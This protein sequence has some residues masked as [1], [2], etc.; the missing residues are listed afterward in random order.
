MSK[1]FKRNFN[2][3]LLRVILIFMIIVHHILLRGCG[4]RELYKNSF[5]NSNLIFSFINAFL[6]VAVNCFFLISGYYGIKKNYEKIVKLV[7]A[8]YS[9]YWAIN[10]VGLIA[11]SQSLDREFIKGLIF[12]ISQYWFIFVYLVLC[13][14][15]P[16]LNILLEHMTVYQKQ[17]LLVFLL[18]IWCGYAFLIDNP[19]FGANDGYSL[20]FA[21]ILYIAGDYIGKTKLDKILPTKSLL[22]YFISSAVNGFIIIYLIYL[23]KTVFAWHMYSYNNPLVLIGSIS[24]FLL[25]K[26]IKNSN[27]L[28]ISRLGRYVVYVYIFH[29]TSLISDIYIKYFL[30]ASEGQLLYKIIYI[31]L[32]SILLFVVG[33]TVGIIYEKLFGLLRKLFLVQ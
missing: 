11:G 30:I 9:V 6:V 25:L 10:I 13:Y 21:I 12:P 33:I 14:I 2:V 7:L 27:L 1:N 3:D 32:F 29:S 22:I 23:G 5:E 18:I 16:Y 31:P 4:L 20:G 28:N 15:G 19:I 24:L 8:V 26:N 17:K